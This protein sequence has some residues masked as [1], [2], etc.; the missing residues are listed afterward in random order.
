[1]QILTKHCIS[2]NSLN[3]WCCKDVYGTHSGLSPSLRGGVLAVKGCFLGLCLMIVVGTCRAK[4]SLKLVRAN[5]GTQQMGSGARCSPPCWPL[6]RYL[7]PST[8]EW[9]GA[10]VARSCPGVPVPQASISRDTR[11]MYLCVGWLVTC[12]PLLGHKSRVFF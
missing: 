8:R 4:G 7:R 11:C 1:M 9:N 2:S 3:S 10:D 6:C 5:C 12:P